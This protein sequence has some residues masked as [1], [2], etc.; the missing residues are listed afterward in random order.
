[1]ENYS[2]LLKQ[3]LQF[4]DTKA[5]ILANVLGYDISYI[6]KWCNGAK[7]PSAKNLHVI[8]KKMSALLQKKSQIIN[9]KLHFF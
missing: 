1:M 7:I 2:H 5:I 8:H 3:L 4:S 6:S 9:K